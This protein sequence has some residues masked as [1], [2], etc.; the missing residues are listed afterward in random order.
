MKHLPLIFAWS[1]LW[2]GCFLS[3]AC[4]TPTTAPARAP[5][6][7]TPMY[8]PTPTLNVTRTATAA[9]VA[10]RQA[11]TWV[12]QLG[13][14]QNNRLAQI[15]DN[16]FDMAVIDLARDGGDYFTPAEISTVKASGKLIL[17]YL[18]IGA[19]EDYRPERPH[20]EQTM[21]DIILERVHGWPEERYVKY[22]DERWWLVVQG[23]VEQALSA[24]FD[25]VY[26]DLIFAYQ[27]I[28]PQSVG[29]SRVELAH[30]MVNLIARLAAHARSRSPQFLVVAQNNPELYTDYDQ[31]LGWQQYLAAIDGLSV[32]NMYYLDTGEP[33][34]EAWCAENIR[35][36]QAVLQAGKPVFS[37]DY[38]AIPS[39]PAKV[40]D[41][42]RRARADGFVPYVSTVGLP[43]C[44][45]PGVSPL[46]ACK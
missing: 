8:K 2:L 14:Y 15:A 26:L 13:Y 7:R 29:F 9:N 33:C 20:V 39:D 28:E 18:D 40:T 46:T 37:V 25:G 34:T 36:A 27:D 21:A 41:A 45:L 35:N 31:P 22:W 38:A 16:V 19:I 24:G 43:A 5:G 23:R 11:Q 42:Y 10:L 17:A 32:E 12:I 3:N 1:A 4:A 44:Y 30:A 6:R